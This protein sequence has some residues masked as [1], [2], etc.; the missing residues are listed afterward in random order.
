MKEIDTYEQ[1]FDHA[2][3]LTEG[4]I[5]GLDFTT[6]G[7]NWKAYQ[8]KDAC[9]L[10]CRFNPE[11][12]AILLEAGAFVLSSPEDLPYHPFR[13]DLYN[14]QELL[15]VEDG[16]DTK[17]L[18]IYRHF[19]RNRFNPGMQEA[20]WQRIHD[21][22]IDTAL[23]RILDRDENG[24][25]PLKCVAVMGGHSIE[26][27]HPAYRKVSLLCQQLTKQGYFIASGGGPGI[28]EAA[29]MGACLAKYEQ[30]AVYDSISMMKQAPHYAADGFIEAS[31]SVLEK[32]PEHTENLAIPT[33]F[34]GH[35]PSN[36]FASHIAKYFSNSIR[37]DTLLAIALHGIIFAP[38]SAGT[39]QEIFMDAAQNHYGTYNY[40]SPMIFLDKKHY[41]HDTMIYPILKKLS[42]GKAYA[43][44][45]F[46]S[47]EID[48]II[49]FI[50]NHPP[51]RK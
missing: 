1:F 31:I 4:V 9:F 14:W 23:D 48:E 34:Y 17:D 39:T 37:E 25:S 35:E 16:D 42:W 44:L 40:Y 41:E 13:K 18:Q 5:R 50:R 7:I 30:D 20:L 12:V 29:N 24:A 51:I 3:D 11:D 8:L 36:V 43:D 33:W 47:D 32:Y 45:L 22:A 28:M 46:V 38:G 49:Q 27:T 15:Q 26:R 10:Q 21:F 6:I 2:F 19:S